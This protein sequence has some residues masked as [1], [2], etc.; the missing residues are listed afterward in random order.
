MYTAGRTLMVE[1]ISIL[2]AF[3][4][5]WTPGYQNQFSRIPAQARGSIHVPH[6]N[7]QPQESAFS[8]SGFKR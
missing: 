1:H 7:M 8:H 3:H 2:T 4:I 5:G 6:V